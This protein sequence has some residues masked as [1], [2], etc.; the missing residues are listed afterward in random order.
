MSGRIPGLSTNLLG[1]LYYLM[2]VRNTA[3]DHQLPSRTIELGGGYGA[4]AYAYC[5]SK[6]DVS[7]AIIDLPEMLSIQQYFLTQALPGHQIVC[8]GGCRI[9]QVRAAEFF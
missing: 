5:R 7:Y 1:M 2:R 3:P 9:N 8:S 4:F 6:P